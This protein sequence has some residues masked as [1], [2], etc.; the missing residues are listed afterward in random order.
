MQTTTE[1][2]SE[3]KFRALCAEHGGPDEIPVEEMPQA[4]A[5]CLTGSDEFLDSVEDGLRELRRFDLI[6]NA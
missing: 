2:I 6:D 3:E 1:K 4:V 5:A